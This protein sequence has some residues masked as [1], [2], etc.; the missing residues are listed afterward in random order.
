MTFK[1][2]VETANEI[3]ATVQAIVTIIAV[4]IGGLWTYNLFIKGR[5]EYPHANLEQKISHVT[6]SE[7]VNLLRIGIDVNNTGDIRMK[8]GRWTIRV[9]QIL[10]VRCPKQGVCAGNEVNEALRVTERQSDR[11][12]WPLIAE[13]DSSFEHPV[14]IEPGEKQAL[15]FEFVIPSEVKVARVYS[16]FGNEQKL[17]EGDEGG[18]AASSYYDFRTPSGGEKK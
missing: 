3:A 4:I 16:H 8:I 5:K 12:S 7:G 10:P 9:Q 18:W 17:R 15:E 14:D 2:K 1:K 11:F 13:R 6:L